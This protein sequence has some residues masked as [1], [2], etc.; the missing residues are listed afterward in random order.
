ML[1]SFE[2]ALR[3]LHATGRKKFGEE[4]LVRLAKRKEKLKQAYASLDESDRDPIQYSSLSARTAYVFAYAPTR[5]EYTREFLMRHRIAVGKSLF[6]KGHIC[7]VSFGGGPASELVGLV[8]YLEDPASGEAVDSI[9]YVVYDKDGDWGDIADDVVASLRTDISIKAE[10]HAVDAADQLKMKEINLAEVDLVIFSYIMSELAKL[11][12]RDKISENFR[13]TLS[14]MP[15]KSKILFIDNKHKIFIDYFR[16][17]KLVSGLNQKSDNGDSVEFE[18]PAMTG[19]F[20]VLE[21]A[22][23]WRPRTDLNSVSK[24]IIRTNK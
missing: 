7:V 6:E 2:S 11:E 14:S 20:G 16:Q 15:V 24:L 22:L 21:K 5:A 19:T 10:Y 9:R 4:W 23:D 13:R 18:L 12:K 3:K 8:K 17:C 1:D